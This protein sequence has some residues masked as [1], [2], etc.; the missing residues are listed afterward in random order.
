MRPTLDRV[1]MRSR[2]NF[3]FPLLPCLFPSDSAPRTFRSPVWCLALPHYDHAS[4]RPRPWD[5]VP[6]TR[7]S[8]AP[9]SLWPRPS[10]RPCLQVGQPPR[11]GS[12]AR[13]SRRPRP[14]VATPIP[15]ATPS[16][17]DHALGP[18]PAHARFPGPAFGPASARPAVSRRRVAPSPRPPR[19]LSSRS[20][21]RSFPAGALCA[22]CSAALP[23]PAPP[24]TPLTRSYP[25]LGYR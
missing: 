13:V 24:P 4:C 23:P 15:K 19:S 17:V 5:G 2:A 22:G 10:R 1:R 18:G 3:F 14:M 6:R 7:V 25:G 12:R 16:L 20:P 9:P 8:P 11:A 21:S